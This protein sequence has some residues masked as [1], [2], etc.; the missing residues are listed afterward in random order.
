MSPN[1][2]L[3]TTDAAAILGVDRA[4]VTRWVRSG[5]LEPEFTLSNG[6]MVFD[7]QYILDQVGPA[8]RQ[9]D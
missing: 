3:T 6:Q 5:R 8:E 9:T 2:K 4:T 7:L 1:Q